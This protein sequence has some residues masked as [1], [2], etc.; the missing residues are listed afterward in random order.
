MSRT[1]RLAGTLL[2]AHLLPLCVV[3]AQAPVLGLTMGGGEATDLRGARAAAVSLAPSVT[4]HPSP[5]TLF[6]FS[7]RG[8]RFGTGVWSA[9]GAAGLLGRA[10]LSHRIT[11][12]VQ[13][14]GDVTYTSW[15]ATYLQA[16]LQSALE[17]RVGV[18]TLSG[19]GKA[20]VARVSSAAP[21]PSAGILPSTSPGREDTRQAI[22]AVWGASARIAEAGAV[23]LRI[24]Y[25]EE[26]LALEDGRLVDR[27]GSAELRHGPLTLTGSLGLRHA[28]GEERVI[29]GA[30]AAME[31]AR[32][33]ALLAA[34]E[35]Y[36]SNPLTQT[37]AGRSL[38]LGVSLRSG[39]FGGVRA[40]PRPSDA[41]SPAP[42]YTRLAFRDIRA[43]TV[44]VAGDW[45]TWNP[46]RLARAGNGVWYVDVKI[47]PGEYRYAFRVN[48]SAWTVPDGMAAV[49]DGFGGRSAWLSVRE[50]GPAT[51]VPATFKEE[52]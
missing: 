26:H 9:T 2:G 24:R 44:E 47:D 38:N 29:G 7:G 25:R 48:G 28:P 3:A 6:T 8:T 10:P 33:I 17:V 32:G 51:G 11:A 23:S 4:L 37:V 39:S 50:A 45:N 46:I 34:V 30:Q 42:G 41:P 52:R 35:R 49:D 14:T 20:A 22:G 1:G 43:R 40:L 31:V 5:H 13:G 36:A 16:D 27:A 19:G 12:L 18:L 21:V 15:R